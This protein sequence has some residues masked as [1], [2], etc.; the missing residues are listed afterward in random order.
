MAKEVPILEGKI[1]NRVLDMVNLIERDYVNKKKP[2]DFA[3]VA[4]YFTLDSLT[5]IGK[6]DL[7]QV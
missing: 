2:M 5:G 3:Q 4:Q 7:S 1:D 6:L